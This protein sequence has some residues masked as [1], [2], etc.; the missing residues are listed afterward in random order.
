MCQ[1]H[2]K[3]LAKMVF[4]RFDGFDIIIPVTYSDLHYWRLSGNRLLTNLLSSEAGVTQGSIQNSSQVRVSCV[5][6][7]P[8]RRAG[9]EKSEERYEDAENCWRSSGP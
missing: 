8:T 2:A 7:Q 5:G 3:A 6:M 4:P 1:F 9:G